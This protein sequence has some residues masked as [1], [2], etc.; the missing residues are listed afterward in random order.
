[1]QP[2][3]NVV[4]YDSVGNPLWASNSVST[5]NQV[6]TSKPAA[7][8]AGETLATGGV[9]WS[10]TKK[11]YLTNQAD[12]NVVVR[13]AA[14][15]IVYATNTYNSGGVRPYKVQNTCDGILEIVDNAGTILWQ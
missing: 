4:A 9:L 12:G 3:R 10:A 11:Y 7:L 6:D 5:A 13:S 1:M 2:D 15:K 8:Y 14:G